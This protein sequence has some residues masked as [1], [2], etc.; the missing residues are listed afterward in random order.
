VAARVAS[1]M[2]VSSRL[3]LPVGAVGDAT[4]IKLATNMISAATIEVLS[5]ALAVIRAS[6]VSIDGFQAALQENLAN[7]GLS[8]LKLPAM[9]SKDFEP[10]FSL[11]NMTKDM[12]AATTLAQSLGF[13]L[14]AI[15]AFLSTAEHL[16]GTEDRAKDYSVV[17]EFFSPNRNAAAPP[18]SAPPAS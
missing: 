12:K 4:V 16:S 2:A 6:G 18:V 7:S 10:R 17:S 5:E 1:I 9:L 13:P 8:Q 14:P 3:I 11:A 15:S